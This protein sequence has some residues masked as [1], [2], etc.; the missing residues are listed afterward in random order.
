MQKLQSEI[1]RLKSKPVKLAFHVGLVGNVTPVKCPNGV[2]IVLARPKVC[3]CCG[4]PI[5]LFN[6][7]DA[8]YP[9]DNKS[10]VLHRVVHCPHSD[11][12]YQEIYVI[13][14]Y[15]LGTKLHYLNG[16]GELSLPLVSFSLPVGK[17]ISF[18]VRKWFSVIKGALVTSR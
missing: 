9:V 2:Q 14:N 15:L 5:S 7:R 12:C 16:D 1:E 3:D 17:A 4:K 10:S 13:F 11:K 18:N 8:H 6:V